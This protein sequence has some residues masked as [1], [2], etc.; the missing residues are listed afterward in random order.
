MDEFVA[1]FDLIFYDHALSITGD[2]RAGGELKVI[3][4]Q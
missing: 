1:V 3:G 4:Q 2:Q